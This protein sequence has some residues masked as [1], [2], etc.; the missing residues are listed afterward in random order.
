MARQCFEEHGPQISTSEIA[1]RLNISQAT[2]FSRFG[3]K[4]TLL[5][6]AMS[7]RNAAEWLDQ[8]RQGPMP[9]RDIR[10]EFVSLARAFQSFFKEIAPDLEILRSAGVKSEEIFANPGNMPLPQAA[11]NEWCGWIERAQSKG[12]MAK[13]P[14]GSLALALIGALQAHP[15]LD[16]Y[17]P[18]AEGLPREEEFVSAWMDAVWHGLAPRISA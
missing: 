4:K 12:L 14:A 10:E 2:L 18:I 9:G 5:I 15:F 13:V 1:K 7:P 3:T 8:L 16:D 6:A 11:F 17:F